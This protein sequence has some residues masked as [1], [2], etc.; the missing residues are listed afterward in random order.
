ML[1]PPPHSNWKLFFRK[2]LQRYQAH[3]KLFLIVLGK[4]GENLDLLFNNVTKAKNFL[5][6]P[7]S[8]KLRHPVKKTLIEN[9][10]FHK[11][12]TGIPNASSF[13]MCLS[14]SASG[15]RKTSQKFYSTDYPKPRNSKNLN[16]WH[17][18]VLRMS[19]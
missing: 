7:H 1:S 15:T 3:I 2:C 14:D 18:C 16:R 17:S 19:I 10:F 9:L 4:Q 5:E 13:C 8:K 11:I 12:F 6:P